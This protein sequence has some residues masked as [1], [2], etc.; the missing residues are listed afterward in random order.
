MMSLFLL[1]YAEI[2]LKSDR[3]RRRFINRLKE[4]IENN[5]MGR[6]IDHI[7]EEERGRLFVET[8]DPDATAE[9][10]KRINGIHSFSPV[11]PCPSSWDGIMECLK[12]VGRESISENMSFGLKVKRVGKH[13]YSS[14]D[15]A[16]NGGS[17]VLS[18]L[19]EG[20]N[21]VDLRDPDIWF[22][23]E[24]RSDRAYVFTTRVRGKGGMPSSTQG[25]SI[26]YLPGIG[27][28]DE[29]ERDRINLRVR[30]SRL[31][32]ERRGVK[33]IPCCWREDLDMW[34]D[35]MAGPHGERPFYIEGEGLE[36]ALMSALEKLDARAV[37]YPITMDEIPSYPL[38]HDKGESVAVFF[39]TAAM[40]DEELGA[41]SDLFG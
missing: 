35:L 31:L 19:P 41:W 37:V 14:Q 21:S 28:K 5:L 2:G 38:I 10:L 25:R 32:M 12:K 3:V 16:I 29:M 7:V 13:P 1:R 8:S 39:P 26:L 18:H 24:I 4:D 33:V 15:I 9:V 6:S 23:V 34:T 40:D 36:S 22:E 30:I 17:A 27:D 20:V 11:E